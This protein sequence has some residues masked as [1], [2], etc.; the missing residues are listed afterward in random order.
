MHK[1]L[2]VSL[3]LL[4]VFALGQQDRQPKRGE[5][6]TSNEKHEPSQSSEPSR[7]PTSAPEFH[8]GSP[9][10]TNPAAYDNDNSSKRQNARAKLIGWLMG[11]KLTDWL[12]VILTAA[13]VI[14]TGRL[15]KA[16]RL[17]IEIA[18]NGER[19]WLFEA[20]SP[21]AAL[22]GDGRHF[23]A[24]KVTNF[25]NSP[26]WIVSVA[27]SFKWI[28]DSDEF[29]D[30]VEYGRINW[31]RIAPLD[32]AD[33]F[34]LEIFNQIGDDSNI[35]EKSKIA[36]FG[37]VEYRDRFNFKLSKPY[38]LKFCFVSTD[39]SGTGWTYGPSKYIDR[40]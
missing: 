18:I 32:P 33:S 31:D 38:T 24:V 35:G 22:F 6:N 7:Q 11:F 10:A 1:L 27:G 34:H 16:V 4:N 14:V 3:V 5:R 39:S 26:T 36:V 40:T 23:C 8:L 21:Y 2:I 37:W 25:G 15:L 13:Y 20:D 28:S 29:P 9:V 30:K 19:A 12:M 17:Q